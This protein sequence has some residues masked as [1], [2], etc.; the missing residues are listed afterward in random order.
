[1]QSWN[2]NPITGDYVMVKGSPEE[3]DSLQVPAYFRLK[4]KRKQWLYTPNDQFGSDY[5]TLKKRPAENANQRLEQIAINALQPIVTDGRASNIQ[6]DVV[7]NTRNGS[8]LHVTITDA[9][10]EVEVQ[11]FSGLGT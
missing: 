7:E 3:T 1:M 10:G 6:A 5:F 9:S 4:T 2:V 8:G 11:T